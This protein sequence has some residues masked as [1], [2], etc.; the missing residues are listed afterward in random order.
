[1]GRAND[2]DDAARRRATAGPCGTRVGGGRRRSGLNGGSP[3]DDGDDGA[4]G[5]ST[6]ARQ[7]RGELR[8]Q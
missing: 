4:K 1:M 5:G 8:R 3:T 2:G 7:R 6:R